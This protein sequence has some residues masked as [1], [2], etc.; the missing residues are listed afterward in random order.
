MMNEKQM[1][2]KLEE[3]YTQNTKNHEEE[4]Q[5]RLK[6]E[7]KLNNMHSAHRDLE[8]RYK[9][10]LQD[11]SAA[12]KNIKMLNETLQNRTD[13]IT[14]LKT[15]QAEHETEI[16]QKREELESSRRELNIKGRQLKENDIRTQQIQDSLD[17][18][19]Y[20]VQDA[21]KENTEMKLKMDVF[22]STCD[23]LMSEKKHLTL[24][25]KETKELQHIYEE[26]TK[27]LMEDL[28]N[29]TG[30]LQMNKREMIGF[31]EVNRERET[32]IQELK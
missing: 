22:Q 29:T 24:E 19:R 16:A 12:Q 21:Q 14:Q 10:V 32:K 6:F 30:E 11:L 7:S 4:V 17:L 20:K 2:L 5:L 13:E 27:Q 15:T 3:D 28:Q 31:N 1:R 8:T 25:L 9:R 26:K 23:G 18:F